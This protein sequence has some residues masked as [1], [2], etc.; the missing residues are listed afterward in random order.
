MFADRNTLELLSPGRNP[1]F[2]MEA[3]NPSA[4][5]RSVILH[6]DAVEKLLNGGPLTDPASHAARPF[7][8]R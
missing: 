7:S 6:V 1:A 2:G 5:R 4:F 3:V 8:S